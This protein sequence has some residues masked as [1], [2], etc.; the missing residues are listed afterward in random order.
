MMQLHIS[1][2]SGVTLC[3]PIFAVLLVHILFFQLEILSPLWHTH[4][5]ESGSAQTFPQSLEW[6]FLAFK[7]C[8]LW[9]NLI[10]MLNWS[11]F[12]ILKAFCFLQWPRSVSPDCSNS[13]AEEGLLLAYPD[14]IYIIA[15]AFDPTVET[16]ITKGQDDCGWMDTK[17]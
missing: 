6:Q 11:D 13:L 9:H 12:S 1:R 15:P 17:W 4:T 14:V 16:C 5:Q 7:L 10:L 3:E 2:R 8:L